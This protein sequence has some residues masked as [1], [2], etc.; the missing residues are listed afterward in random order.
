[1]L[2]SFRFS[3]PEIVIPKD[4]ALLVACPGVQ[5]DDDREVFL[6]IRPFKVTVQD[7]WERFWQLDQPHL[8]VSN[9]S[10]YSPPQ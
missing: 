3:L 10:Q 8:G 1:V 4:M 2:R 6:L 5:A 7:E 9:Y